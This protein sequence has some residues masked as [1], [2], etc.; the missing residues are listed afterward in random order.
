MQYTSGLV[1]VT[2]N[3]YVVTG[4]PDVNFTSNVQAGNAFKVQGDAAV[5]TVAS[6]PDATTLYLTAPYQ[7]STASLV[8]YQ[9]TCDYTPNLGLA[10]VN[11]GDQDWPVH[12]TQQVLRKLDSY[13]GKLFIG[14][15]NGNIKTTTGGSTT[16][17]STV[18]G[19]FGQLKVGFTLTANA[20]TRTIVSI[21]NSS[22]VVVD[23]TVDW[24]NTNTGYPF[25]YGFGASALKFPDTDTVDG[26]H[27]SAT[28]TA[29]TL[30]PLNSNS[31]YPASVLPDSGVTAGT[32]QSVTVDAKGRVTAG[33]PSSFVST[34]ANYTLVLAD[35]GKTFIHPTSD[36]T[37][38]T[39]TIPSNASVAFPIETRIKFYNSSAAGG[40][41]VAVATDTLI[42]TG[43]SYASTSSFTLKSNGYVEMLK[44][45]ATQWL[46]LPVGAA[47]VGATTIL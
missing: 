32:Y 20:T 43:L 42:V 18:A 45:S 2:T 13:L 3:N 28:V 36:V 15:G 24:Y 30:L 16:V 33:A 41:T 1:S 17:T 5:Y 26:L 22:T 37:A 44:I 4:S 25:S 40:L 35:A 29:N 31:Q 8:R 46:V 11:I 21:T 34:V 38:R 12:L 19:A 27:A 9:V 10:E 23:Q 14:Q 7:G 6:I 39:I 47:I